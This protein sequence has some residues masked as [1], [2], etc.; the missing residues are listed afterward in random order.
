[1]KGLLWDSHI[2]RRRAEGASSSSL[3]LRKGNT[4]ASMTNSVQ[5]QDHTSTFL[6]SYTFSDMTCSSETTD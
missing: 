1:M 5:P 2:L 3:I 6:P 4:P